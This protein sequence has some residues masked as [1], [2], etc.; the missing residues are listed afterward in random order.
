MVSATVLGVS[1]AAVHAT[2]FEDCFSQG[3]LDRK[4]KG[5]TQVIKQKSTSPEDRVQVHY[6]RA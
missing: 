3:D 2:A 5:C 6:G 1:A 4:V